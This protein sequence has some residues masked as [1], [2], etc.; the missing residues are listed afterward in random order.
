M[1]D[2]DEDTNLDLKMF[3]STKNMGAVGQAAKVSK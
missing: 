3:G 2:F 1:E